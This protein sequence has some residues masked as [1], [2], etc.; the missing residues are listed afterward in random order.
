MFVIRPTLFSVVF[1]QS[2]IS[3]LNHVKG[4][5]NL[6]WYTALSFYLNH[7][8]IGAQRIS[9][10]CIVY[11]ISPFDQAAGVYFVIS[12]CTLLFMPKIP[13]LQ[14]ANSNSIWPRVLMTDDMGRS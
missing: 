14:A 2:V 4:K 8:W 13:P 1:V 10:F 7:H 11:C 6:N 5:Y 12:L 3:I 9:F